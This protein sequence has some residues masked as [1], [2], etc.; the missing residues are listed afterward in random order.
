MVTPGVIQGV[1]PDLDFGRSAFLRARSASRRFFQNSCCPLR[2]LRGN[3]PFRSLAIWKVNTDAFSQTDG[4]RFAGAA[5]PFAEWGSWIVIDLQR[6]TQSKKARIL[7]F[8]RLM[9]Q[10]VS[11]SGERYDLLFAHLKLGKFRLTVSIA[12]S[13]L[14]PRATF[15][16]QLRR[17]PDAIA[18]LMST[19]PRV[20]IAMTEMPGVEMP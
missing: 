12:P 2:S 3:L 9:A 10:L 5:R 20:G 7:A 8:S 1:I 18:Q 6:G 4:V 19:P 11:T 16:A 15:R 13:N 14:R 17:A